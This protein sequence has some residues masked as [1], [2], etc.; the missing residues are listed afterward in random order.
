M[1]LWLLLQQLR[2]QHLLLQQLLLVL[3]QVLQRQALSSAYCCLLLRSLQH[4]GEVLVLLF[5]E[6]LELPLL[7]LLVGCL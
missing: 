5:V 3:Q 2:L 4:S 1:L 7:L 6:G